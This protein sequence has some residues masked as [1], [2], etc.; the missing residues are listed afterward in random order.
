MRKEGIPSSRW[1]FRNN[2]L[3]CLIGTGARTRAESVKISKT[4]SDEAIA[5]QC[6]FLGRKYRSE[7]SLPPT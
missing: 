7:K 4:W 3:Q 1:G 6:A 5:D 2:E